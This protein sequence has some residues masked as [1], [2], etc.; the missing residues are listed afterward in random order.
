MSSSSEFN[1]SITVTSLLAKTLENAAK[2]LAM[3]CISECARRHNFNA[4][5][6]IR[7]LG[8]ENLSLVRKEM[9]KR[10][11]SKKR[12]VS[13]K[14]AKAPK[15][16]IPM[17]FSHNNVS[18]SCC[19][20]LAYNRGLFTQCS[21]A[22]M[23][24]GDYCQGCQ[25]EADKNAS[26]IPD[27]GTVEMRLNSGLYEFKDPKGRSATRYVKVLQKVNVSIEDAIAEA[28]KQNIK[29]SNDHFEMSNAKEGRRGRPKKIASS[30]V[31]A[32]NVTDLFA[33]LTVDDSNEEESDQESIETTKKARKTKV[34]EEEKAANKAAAEQER[35]AKKAEKEAQ[36]AA[37][38]EQKRKE[39]EAQLAA[40]KEQKRKER[41]E[42]IAAEKAAREAKIAQEKEKRLKEK[43]AKKKPAKETKTGVKKS[44]TNEETTGA[45]EE[46]AP[47]KVTVSRIQIE[48]VQYLKSSANI[49]YNPETK[50]EI[51]LW[52]P[53]TKTIDALP[54]EEE[55]EE[56]EA[57]ESDDE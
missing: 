42:K 1:A 50:E 10:T 25:S 21:R 26:G 57:Y 27:C 3:K 31:E 11:A 55:E 16:K 2:E 30:V 45:A 33:K 15:S 53:A 22:K 28:G 34:S 43:E 44:A 49:L 12:T 19:Q 54:E 56:E 24:N 13:V 48:G 8:L 40:E 38:K 39:K 7:I 9:N 5:E 17:P 52:N 35:V 47:K 23:D 32:D 36:L 20:G 51:G 6:E 4:D 41:E 14:E 37:E 46:E 18:S 29:L